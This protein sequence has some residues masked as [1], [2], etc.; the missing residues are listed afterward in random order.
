M[1][2]DYRVPAIVS[3]AKILRALHACG[4]RGAVQAELVRATG[5]SKSS[6]H[7]LLVTLEEE[8]FV[9]RDSR[10]RE[11]RLGPALVT[12]G[13]AAAGQAGLID[14]A[15]E[16]LAPLSAERSLSFAIAQPIDERQ[17]VVVERFYPPEGVHVGIRLGSSFGLYDGALGKC[18]LAA[19]PDDE[20]E[21]ALREK[22]IPAHTERTVTDPR[23]LREEVE[24]VRERGYAVS[25]Q[26]LNE[27]NAVVAPVIGRGG[28]PGLFLLALGFNEQLGGERLREIGELLVGVA[29]EISAAAGLTD[30]AVAGH[31]TR[32]GA[33]G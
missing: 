15:S 6:M 10:T 30:G 2:K 9:M 27:N 19:L 21:A 18:L 25:Q 22:P 28:R 16:R 32:S 4:D 13:A 33:V 11:Y 12:L 14:L 26:E 31:S 23:K 20:L 3:A 24:Q 8:G 29:R 1:S 5:L 7:N 17:A